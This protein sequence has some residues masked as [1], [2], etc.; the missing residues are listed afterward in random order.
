MTS[1]AQASRAALAR[2]ARAYGIQQVFDAMRVEPSPNGGWVPTGRK[3]GL[4]P[5]RLI[6][7][8][9]AAPEPC[10]LPQ[11]WS[12]ETQPRHALVQPKIDG[13]RALYVDTSIITREGQPLDCALHCLPALVELE[14]L[15]GCKMVFDGE[16]R[17]P[18]GFE[19]TLSAMRRGLGVGTFHL[20]DAI[21]YAEWARNKCTERLDSRLLKL[22]EVAGAVELTFVEIVDFSFIGGAEEAM[23]LANVEWSHGGEGLVVKDRLAPYSRG[24]SNTWLKLK[25]KQTF[26]GKVV[27]MLLKDGRCVALMVK[28]PADSPSPGKV[29]RIGSNIPEELREAMGRASGEYQDAVAEIGFNDTTDTGNLRGGYFIRLRDDKKEI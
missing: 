23:A 17:E 10:C 13:I 25:Q 16:Y 11:T 18:E 5:L 1:F 9:S 12:A 28:M 21:P 27:D 20:F 29:V 7:G 2:I 15:Y 8:M 26:D 14:R 4:Q 19:A 3:P 24:K 22:D 6:P